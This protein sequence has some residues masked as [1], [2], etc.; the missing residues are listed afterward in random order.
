M[1]EHMSTGEKK[2]GNQ[3]DCSPNIAVL[4][5]GQEVRPSNAQECDCSQNCCSD[6]N[7]SQPIDR[8]CNGWVRSIGE[9]AC[10]P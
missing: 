3:T 9:L 1:V 5:D 8:S 2:N 10:D 7:T 6:C 4:E